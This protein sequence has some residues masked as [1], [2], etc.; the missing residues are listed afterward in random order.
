M[1]IAYLFAELVDTLDLISVN[2]PSRWLFLFYGCNTSLEQRIQ[3]H[4]TPG[5]NI[6]VVQICL[7][8]F[9]FPV[10]CMAS[11]VTAITQFEVHAHFLSLLQ[12]IA[13]I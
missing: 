6:Q 7:F 3:M 13:V 11:P 12:V 10:D 4:C 5:K 8:S 9:P 2:W 1:K